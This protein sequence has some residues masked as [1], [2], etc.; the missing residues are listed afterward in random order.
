MQFTSITLAL[1]A[2]LSA[3]SALASIDNNGNFFNCKTAYIAQSTPRP[4]YCHKGEG[5]LTKVYPATH[6]KETRKTNG[7]TVKGDNYGQC[8]VVI[9]PET[10]YPAATATITPCAKPKVA[11]LKMGSP[12][13]RVTKTVEATRP[14]KTTCVTKGARRLQILP[15]VEVKPKTVTGK[16]NT[17][18]VHKGKFFARATTILPYCK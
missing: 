1:T 12:P 4:P 16:D 17:V 8:T 5:I 10:S 7:V 18:T 13:N 14:L 9:Y 2:L 3:N 11:A 15:A 6:L